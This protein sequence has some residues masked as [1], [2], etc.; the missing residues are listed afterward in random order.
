LNEGYRY[1]DIACRAARIASEKLAQWFGRL[2]SNSIENK[3]VNDWVSAA[4]HAAEEAII[5]LLQRE[6][7][8]FAILTEET[9]YLPGQGQGSAYCWI[10]DPLDGTTNFIRGFPLWAVS[11]ALEHRPDRNRKW[12]EIIAGTI[13]IPLFKETFFAIKGEGAY[14]NNDLILPKAQSRPVDEALLCTG[15]PF[16][17]QEYREPYLKLFGKVMAECANV[18]RPGAVTIDLC[19]TALGTFDGFWELDLSPWDIA[20]G[21][22]II[23]EAGGRTANFLDSIDFLSSGDIVAGR[24]PVFERLLEL[25]QTYFPSPRDVNKAPLR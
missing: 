16:R 11:V 21:A 25:T 6:T 23:Q 17:A 1:I 14:R 9:G 13:D 2:E 24:T 3:S 22:L 19:Y 8:N 10:V 20:A 15:F 7:P 12:G 4:D 18:R 5:G